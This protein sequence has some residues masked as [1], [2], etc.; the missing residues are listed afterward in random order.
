[1]GGGEFNAS[2]AAMSV[3]LRL[4]PQPRQEDVGSNAHP[5]HLRA[6]INMSQDKRLYQA[7]NFPNQYATCY[8]TIRKLQKEEME[9]Q[10]KQDEI[11][12]EKA[13]REH[14]RKKRG[15]K[16]HG[17]KKKKRSGS[18]SSDDDD[19]D[20]DSSALS[21]A[22]SS[23]S[24][25]SV[26]DS[27]VLDF[28]D[29]ELNVPWDQEANDGNDATTTS[30]RKKKKQRVFAKKFGHAIKPKFK[31]ANEGEFLPIDFRED[32]V[33][34]SVHGKYVVRFDTQHNVSFIGLDY[35]AVTSTEELR[36]EPFLYMGIDELEDV[37][38][39]RLR[40]RAEKKTGSK[41]LFGILA[42]EREVNGLLVYKPV[43][44]CH[45]FRK[46]V[47]LDML[48]I[49]FYTNDM[50]RVHLSRVFPKSVRYSDNAI[51][52]VCDRDIH[53]E[54]G[55]TVLVTYVNDDSPDHERVVCER[56]SVLRA[57]SK[58]QNTVLVERPIT[59]IRNKSL[60]FEVLDYKCCLVFSLEDEV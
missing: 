59:K 25:E 60:S 58:G 47:K 10:M 26:D 42:Q 43:N 51:E 8:Y 54:R 57:T 1:M 23:S 22:T 53:V 46:P 24:S 30:R 17:R 19:D 5:S 36:K 31:T 52:L 41:S 27:R 28:S 38:H 9:R 6:F 4:L 15:K 35:V 20:D 32:V 50:R 12:Y 21:S 3:D 29:D 39:L 45:S 11:E 14:E 40:G 18:S 13:R 55:D 33:D 49:S 37:G 7:Q 44:C 48:T 16:Q 34:R 2:Q 56:L